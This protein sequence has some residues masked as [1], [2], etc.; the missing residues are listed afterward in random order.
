MRSPGRR[1]RPS[2]TWTT[3]CC[4]AV[5]AKKQAAALPGYQRAE[6]LHRGRKLLLERADDIGRTMAREPAARSRTRAEVV[7][8]QDTAFQS[9][10]WPASRRSA[11][12]SSVRW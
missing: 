7:R 2:L 11:T 12:R 9:A 5:A 4:A 6:L 1:V 3:R 8:S 10:L